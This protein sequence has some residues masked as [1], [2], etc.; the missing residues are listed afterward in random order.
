M[1]EDVTRNKIL[2]FLNEKVVEQRDDIEKRPSQWRISKLLGCPGRC[3]ARIALKH[4]SD[5]ESLFNFNPIVFNPSVMPFIPRK[6]IE[7]ESYF[8]KLY[9]VQGQYIK[10]D[11]YADTMRDG[12]KTVCKVL[13]DEAQKVLATFE[14]EPYPTQ[15][16]TV[17]GAVM[18]KLS[19]DQCY[20]AVDLDLD[21]RWNTGYLDVHDDKNA[22]FEHFVIEKEEYVIPR[23]APYQVY[24]TD[25][26]DHSLIDASQIVESEN[27]IN[28]SVLAI[29]PTDIQ[30][31]KTQ[32]TSLNQL[33]LGHILVISLIPLDIYT[34][35]IRNLSEIS[36]QYTSVYTT[37]LSQLKLKELPC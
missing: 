26:T 33:A 9:R 28:I 10:A 32:V 19:W 14:G 27:P 21:V 15:P 25:K 22:S 37:I 34:I 30:L 12:N 4:V 16:D 36:R 35:F 11:K 13:E 5:D 3:D 7:K 29:T 18:I 17:H 1:R 23:K 8:G 31:F 6:K 24:A 2:N 20:P